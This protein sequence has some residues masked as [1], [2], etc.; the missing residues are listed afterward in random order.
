MKRFIAAVAF[1]LVCTGAF[2]QEVILDNYIGNFV[3]SVKHS[4]AVPAWNVNALYLDG[5]I[6]Y[7]GQGPSIHALDVSSPLEPR[8]LSSAKAAGMVRQITVQNGYLFASCREAGVYIFDVHD[9]HHI[10][11][12]LRYDPVE[13]ATG[14]EVAGDVLFLATRQNGVEM[15]DI[16][17]INNPKHIRMEKTVESQSVTYRDGYLYSGE[18]SG[19]EV[20]V[21]DVHDMATVKTLRTANMQAFGD[22]V[23]TY[24]KY[25][26][27][28]TGHNLCDPKFTREE[29]WGFGHGLEIF[30]ISKPA[31]PKFVSKIAFDPLYWK[32]ND[33][34]TPRPFSKG[35]YV[36]CADAANGIYIVDAHKPKTPSTLTRVDFRK[37]DGGQVAVT[38]C[39]VGKG[40]IYV[41]VFSEHGLMMLECPDAEPCVQPKGVLPV[42]ANYRYPYTT[43]ADSHF[44]AWKPATDA[45][46]RGVAAK[47]RIMYA[48]CSWGGLEILRMREDGKMEKIGTGPMAYAGDVKEDNGKLYVAEGTAGFAIY[49]I[50]NDTVLHE[51]GRYNEFGKK[52]GT[53]PAC[54]WIFVPDATHV[55]A[56]CRHSGYQFFDVSNPAQIRFIKSIEGGPGWDKYV[57]DKADSKGWYPRVRHQEGVYWVN[58]NDPTLTQRKGAGITSDL[59]DGICLFRGDRFLT[60][61]NRLK[62]RKAF[63][64]SSDQID[65]PK[66]GAEGNLVGMPCWD[67][68]DRVALTY[69]FDREIRMVDMK[70][71]HHPI[72]LWTEQVFGYPETATFWCGKL[73]VPCGYQGLLVEK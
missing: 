57:C 24:G 3:K 17:D 9:P 4:D 16:S 38:S 67:G 7:C 62:V 50:E 27:A 69:R 65:A 70:D 39:A 40:V 34:W 48:A 29:S 28:S 13:L 61:N 59:T 10:R 20:T 53:N 71:E 37:K 46:V 5:D 26:Y 8:L 55:V 14:I 6:L 56:C 36:A 45:P 44:N 41:S 21:I 22:G 30:D 12:M 60:I 73:A 54:V 33:Y 32:S 58:L 42:N 49:Q 52:N 15:V 1:F 11:T 64:F 31:N 66:N 63:V 25:L 51:I 43:P 23:W 18:W 35:K 19:H 47:G 72:T 2:A 68:G